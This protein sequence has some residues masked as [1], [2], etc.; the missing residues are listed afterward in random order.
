[1]NFLLKN[2]IIDLIKENLE[3]NIEQVTDFGPI[4]KIRVKLE[5]DGEVISETDCELPEKGE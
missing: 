5:F 4:E 1:M 2:E 3:I